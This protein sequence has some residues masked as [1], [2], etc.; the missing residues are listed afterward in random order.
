MTIPPAT[1]VMTTAETCT[2]TAPVTAPW[3]ADSEATVNLLLL[4][5]PML[6]F[7]LAEKLLVPATV[8]DAPASDE[9]KIVVFATTLTVLLLPAKPSTVLPRAVRVPLTVKSELATI[10]A[11]EVTGAAALA[12]VVT[13]LTVSVCIPAA[14]AVPTNVLPISAV[15]P[16]T[17]MPCV[18]TTAA[19]AVMGPEPA[20]K[21]VTALTVSVWPVDRLPTVTFPANRSPPLATKPALVVSRAL[22][23]MGALFAKAVGELIVTVLLP[24]LL[25]RTVLPVTDKPAV[26]VSKAFAVMGAVLV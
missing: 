25:P 22:A 13:A 7:P 21:V 11:L 20:A 14:A 15:L 9:L 17:V 24:M 1:G 16:V 6:A 12:K 5:V 23:M 2:P 3:K 26:A 8:T 4:L 10:A 19:L 18:A